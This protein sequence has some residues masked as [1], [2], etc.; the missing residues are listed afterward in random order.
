VAEDSVTIAAR[1]WSTPLDRLLPEVYVRWRQ[2]ADMLERGPVGPVGQQ[3]VELAGQYAYYVARIGLHT[4]DRRLASGFGRIAARCAEISGDRLLTGSVACLHF[5][6]A[7]DLHARYG[8]AADVAG[9]AVGQAHPYTKARLCAYRAEASAAGGDADATRDALAE[10]RRN[11]VGLPPM[12]GEALFGEGQQHLYSAV[13]LADIG[14]RD[15][16]TIAGEALAAFPADAYQ[17]HGLGWAAI[18]KARAGHDPGAAADAGLRALDVNRAWPSTAVESRIRR[19]HRTLAREH[20][21]VAEV[22]RFGEAV[23]TLRPAAKV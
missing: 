22:V 10:M 18:G 14:D 19:L 13:A 15:A 3:V 20:G 1:Y 8:K 16:E 21:D 4:G 17:A 7:F 2:L 9:R 11:M 6:V 5:A 23:A 12:P